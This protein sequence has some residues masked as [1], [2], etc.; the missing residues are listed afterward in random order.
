M[1][2]AA[3]NHHGSSWGCKKP[4]GPKRAEKPGLVEAMFNKWLAEAKQ[5]DQFCYFRGELAYAKQFDTYLARLADHL[6]SKANGEF[7]ILSQCGDERGMIYGDKSVELLT[8]REHGETVY[9]CIRR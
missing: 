2:G 5:G 6:L 4:G 3:L 8:R 7:T 1:G 9:L